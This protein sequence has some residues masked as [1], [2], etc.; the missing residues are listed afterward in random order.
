[1]ATYRNLRAIPLMSAMNWSVVLNPGSWGP[2]QGGMYWPGAG[3]MSAWHICGQMVVRAV[4]A[5][6]SAT[7]DGF[8]D[9]LLAN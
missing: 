8:E 5:V 1:M 7:T 9:T 6:E 3:S 4:A 2:R